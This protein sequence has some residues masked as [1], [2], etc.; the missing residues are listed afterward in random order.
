MLS[1]SYDGANAP[2]VARTEAALRRRF[3]ETGAA[4]VGPRCRGAYLTSTKSPG[5]VE[6]AVVAVPAKT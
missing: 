5:A 2:A 6:A 1:S 3:V 4:V